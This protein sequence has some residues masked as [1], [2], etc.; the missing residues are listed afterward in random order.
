VTLSKGKTEIVYSEG[1]LHVITI[2]NLQNAEL[3]NCISTETF[4]NKHIL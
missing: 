3:I 4:N 2:E 1:V